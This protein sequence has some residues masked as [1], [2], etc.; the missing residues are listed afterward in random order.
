MFISTLKYE[1]VIQTC[2]KHNIGIVV[3]VAGFV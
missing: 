3:G 2:K 1:N